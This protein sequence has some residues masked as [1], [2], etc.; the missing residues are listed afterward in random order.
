MASETVQSRDKAAPPA[1][2]ILDR[3]FSGRVRRILK[4]NITAYAFLTPAMVLL[5]TFGIFPIFYAAYVSLFKWRIRQGEYRGLANYVAA[6]GDVA[7]VFFGLI[8]LALITVTITTLYKAGK[9]A[10]EKDIPFKYPLL[11][12]IPAV[13]TAVGMILALLRAVTIFAQSEEFVLG[14]APLGI[15]LMVVGGVS[16]WLVQRYQHVKVAKTAHSVLPNFATPA[17]TAVL[18]GGGAYYIAS[19]TIDQLSWSDRYPLA[20][21]RIQYLIIALVVLAVGYF[22]WNWSMNQNSNVKLVGGLVGAIVMIG[23]GVQ[24]AGWWPTISGDSDPD[25]YLSLTATVFYA[26]FTVPIQLLISMVL[27]VL[28][29]QN[30]KAKGIFRIIFFIPYI[31]PAVATAGIFEAIFSIRATSLANWPFTNGGQDPT[32]A[33]QWLQEASPAFAELGQAMG[34]DAAAAIEWG[35]SLALF[36]IIIYSIWVFVGYDTVIFLAGLGN[37]PNTLYEAARIDGAGR[38]ALFRYITL[39]LLSPTTYF[40][41]VISIIGTF[42]AFNHIW[43]LREPA[44]QGTADT[45]SIYFFQTFFRGTRYGY[46]TSMAV[47]LFVIILLMT[48][49]QNRIA[50]RKVFY[51]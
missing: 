14:N 19:Y 43:V 40:L 34:L 4:E 9:K 36:V 15:L 38:W 46:A 13:I 44:A 22:L 29:Y 39:P 31:A 18:T 30:I 28:L 6:M 49:I 23:M 20:M 24:L 45:A 8:A 17:L 37:I 1:S 33:L 7:Y 10:Q 2:S 25:F 48:I 47:V 5:F 32:A 3:V 41:S 50:A 21:V 11:A 35:P 26:L 12:L 42:K 27:A 51:G 16:S